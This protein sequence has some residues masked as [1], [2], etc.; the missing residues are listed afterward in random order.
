MKKIAFAL[1]LT[2]FV[3]GNAFA[4]LDPDDDGIGI[5]WDP[6]ACVNCVELPV[7]DHLGYLAITHPTSELGV[8][9]WEA[10]IT[11]EGPC[12]VT[13]WELLGNAINVA[14]RPDEF[15]VGLGEPAINPYTY[16]AVVV[17]IV[18]LYIYDETTPVEFFIDGVYFHSIPDN[19]QPAYLD[20]SNYDIIKPLQQIQGSADLPVAIINGDCDGV[21]ATTNESFDSLKALYR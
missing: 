14:S 2:L 16:P 8:G 11:V 17:A 3:A 10:T 1:I 5:Y 12:A 19:S 4:Q 15:I 13:E 20:G 21:V 6:C 7:G 9:G 18:H